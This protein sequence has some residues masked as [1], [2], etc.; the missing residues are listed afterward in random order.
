MHA[1]TKFLNEDYDD[2]EVISVE[3]S[4]KE[5]NQ[6]EEKHLNVNVCDVIV[7]DNPEDDGWNP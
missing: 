2:E 7:G 1:V 6:V 3:D 4:D 5:E